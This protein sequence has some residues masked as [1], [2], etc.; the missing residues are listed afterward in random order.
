MT[1]TT[2]FQVIKFLKSRIISR[3]SIPT[4]LV[5]DNGPQFMG[6]ELRWFCE[7][8]KI[9]HRHAIVKHAQA[10]GQVETTNKTILNGLKNRFDAC[11]ENGQRNWKMYF[12]CCEYTY[13]DNYGDTF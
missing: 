4:I 6:K 1:Y 10:N 9:E 13:N 12:G 5:S 11:M 2:K 7:Q 3:Y 8:L